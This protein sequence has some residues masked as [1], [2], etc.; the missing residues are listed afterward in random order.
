MN[1][2]FKFA[3]P[4][5][6]LTVVGSAMAAVPADVTTALADMKTDGLVVAGAV[7]VAVIAIFAIKFIRK[8]L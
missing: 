2:T 6:L 8:G 5:A 4:A 3:F 7:L 1:K